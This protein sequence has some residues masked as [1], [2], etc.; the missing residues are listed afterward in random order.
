MLVFPRLIPNA[1]VFQETQRGNQSRSEKV[2][3]VFSCFSN[4]IMLSYNKYRKVNL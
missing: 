2:F 1:V 4:W 3:I